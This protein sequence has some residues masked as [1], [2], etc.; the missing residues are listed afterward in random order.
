MAFIA[1]TGSL[2]GPMSELAGMY[3]TI[4]KTNAYLDTIFEII[5]TRGLSVDCGARAGRSAPIG[6]S[7]TAAGGA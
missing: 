5:D 6:S 7:S 4:R 2:F 3:E 1:Y